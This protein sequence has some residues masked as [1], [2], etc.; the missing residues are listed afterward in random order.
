MRRRGKQSAEL[1][2]ALENMPLSGREY[3][4]RSVDLLT[5]TAARNN[6]RVVHVEMKK[7]LPHGLPASERELT[8]A[9]GEVLT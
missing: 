4:H 3:D 5:M 8:A 7:H 9:L 1:V 6:S 2:E